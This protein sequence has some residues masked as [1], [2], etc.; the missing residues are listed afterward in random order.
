MNLKVITREMGRTINRNSPSILTGL[1]IAGF[2]TSIVMAAKATPK[3]IEMIEEAQYQEGRF[4]DERGME[5]IFGPKE[6]AMACWTAYIPTVGMATLSASALIFANNIS[7]RRNA[8]LVSLYTIAESG[9]RDYQEKVIESFGEKKE[10]KLRDEIAQDKLNAN[11]VDEQ[12]IIFTD[13]GDQLCFDVISG[14]YFPSS[15]ETLR[16]IQNEFNARLLNEMTLTM[17]ELYWDMGL[18]AI[19][20]GNSLGWTV[21][22]GLMEFAFSTKLATNNE[23]CIVVGYT[24]TVEGIGF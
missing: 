7:A 4:A 9:L 12:K 15:I 3:A 14:R 19:E 5:L 10:T 24:R 21:E 1:G 17:N 22:K 11:P 18:D 2:I 16:Q 23:P 20:V 13:K 6:R 8:A